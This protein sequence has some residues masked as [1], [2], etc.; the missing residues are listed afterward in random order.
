MLF[1]DVSGFT[2]LS[3]RLD[4]EDV[5]TLMTRVRADAGRGPPLRRHGE[6]VPRRRHHGALRGASRARR[7]RPARGARRARH[8]AC[9][10]DYQQALK[11]R[12]GM[13]FQVRQGLNSGLVVVGSIG[14]DLRMDYT[15]I[16]DTT[17]VAARLQQAADPGAD[18]ALRLARD[19]GLFILYMRGLWT[20][21]MVLDVPRGVGRRAPEPGGG[22]R[23]RR[24]DRG[25]RISAAAHEHAGLA[26]P[27][28]RQRRARADPDDPGP[29][30][31]QADPPRVR[32]R[33]AGVL[34][35]ERRRQLPGAGRPAAGEGDVRRG[36]ASRRE[37]EHARVD[38]VALH[39][40]PPREPGRVLAGAGRST[41]APSR[42]P[43]A[44]WRWP[45]RRA[46]GSTW[47]GSTGSWGRS[48][49]GSIAGTTPSAR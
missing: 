26:S 48:R 8:P 9:P 21:G 14:N 22:C 15:A 7:S 3:A 42:R 2:A 36:A 49:S 27:G 47:P 1:V 12:P 38:E 37:P 24:E 29:R 28:V 4:P 5:H 43:S 40:A 31:R 6:S 17:N 34:P 25:L 39:A 13:T 11:A 35:R 16:G 18:E 46:P 41:G 45:A 10:R 33:D 23:A 19:R 20:R 32:G 30:A 44:P